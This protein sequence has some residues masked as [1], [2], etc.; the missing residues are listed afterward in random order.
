MATDKN[1]RPI[2]GPADPE[3][4]RKAIKDALE[5]GKKFRAEKRKKEDEKAAE[6]ARTSTARR[7]KRTT[8]GAL[9]D[10]KRPRE[11]T[12]EGENKTLS[13]AVDE[14]VRQG[15]EADKKRR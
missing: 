13:E 9:L 15:T 12:A 1:G 6:A 11:R 4:R 7:K 3:T 8:L 10:P 5:D 2:V 14:G